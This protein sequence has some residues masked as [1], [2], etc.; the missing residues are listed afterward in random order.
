MLSPPRARLGTWLSSEPTVHNRRAPVPLWWRLV[1]FV[2]AACAGVT[3]WFAGDFDS[4]ISVLVR[5]IGAT[6]IAVAVH[7]V[8]MNVGDDRPA[9]AGEP[10]ESSAPDRR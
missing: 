1:A 6:A 2:A 9:T 4:W 3:V 7:T 5:L 10:R 8:V